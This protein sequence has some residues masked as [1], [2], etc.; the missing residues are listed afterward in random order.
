MNLI[1]QLLKTKYGTSKKT[2]F[3]QFMIKFKHFQFSSTYPDIMAKELCD[4]VL[5]NVELNVDKKISNI[6]TYHTKTIYVKQLQKEANKA[7]TLY[8]KNPIK[9][10]KLKNS[11][12]A[13]VND[14]KK[15]ININ[16][17]RKLIKHVAKIP[18]QTK[19][20]KCSIRRLKFFKTAVFLLF[21]ERSGK[22]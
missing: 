7:L 1:N 16:K 19:S 8:N 2:N 11:T 12:K 17:K 9:Y 10:K 15:R 6:H 20:S 21:C 5:A 14:T 13:L 18:G 3:H 4:F 22:C